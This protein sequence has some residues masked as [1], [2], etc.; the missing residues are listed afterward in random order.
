MCLESINP[1]KWI[2]KVT[3]LQ[4]QASH[5]GWMVMIMEVDMLRFEIAQVDSL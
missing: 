4:L 1:H 5:L 3:L 2:G